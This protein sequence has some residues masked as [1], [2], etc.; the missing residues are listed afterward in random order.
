MSNKTIIKVWVMV[1]LL[2][3]APITAQI[4]QNATDDPQQAWRTTSTIAA[5]GSTYSPQVTPVGSPTAYSTATTTTDGYNPLA[6]GKPTG[7][8]RAFDNPSDYGQSDESPIGDAV[9]P[10]MLMAMLS[11]GVIYIRRRSRKA[12]N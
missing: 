1:A 11:C 2:M 7:P 10:L 8:R 6:G 9:L 5:S 12:E 4:T 3:S